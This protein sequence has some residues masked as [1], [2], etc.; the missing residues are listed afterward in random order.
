[1]FIINFI[2]YIFF[3]LKVKDLN[4]K[5]LSYKKLFLKIVLENLD[6]F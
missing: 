1:M 4:L 3:Y 5:R 2:F 6:N